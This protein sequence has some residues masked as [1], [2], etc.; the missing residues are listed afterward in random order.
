MRL[1]AL[2]IPFSLLV[3]GQ[4]PAPVSPV[5]NPPV[6]PPK[7]PLPPDTVVAEVDGKKLTAADMDKLLADYPP[8]VQN[9]V[10]ANPARN[11]T[12]LFLFKQLQEMAEKDGVDKQ[13][14]YKQTLDFQRMQILAQGEMNVTRYKTQIDQSEAEK[15]YKEHPE[16]FRQAKV[17]AIYIAFNPQA[18]K[19]LG[20]AKLPS[21]A[22]AKAKA[23]DLR[24]Q[25]LAGTDFGKLASESSDDKVSAAKNGDFGVIDKSSPYPDA[26]KTT[27]LSLNKGEVSEP[28]RQPNGF[29]LIRVN[30]F[31]TKT[32][33]DV[34]PQILEEM[35]QTAFDAWMKG[36]EKRFEVKIETPGYFR[37]AMQAPP[38]PQPH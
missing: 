19:G 31:E 37:P 13:S 6:A 11:L 27:V 9:A 3:C 25:I 18:G 26:L 22:E 12:Q 30:D 17:S 15:V 32:L 16:R 33:F 4:A 1:C 24:K 34:R 38:T 20:D 14:P 7:T 5:P 8:A 35:R 28:V 2:I 23:D 36:L 29:Y 21:E 10:R